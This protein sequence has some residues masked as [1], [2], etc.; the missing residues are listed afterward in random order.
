M[1]DSLPRFKGKDFVS[2]KEC[3]FMFMVAADK[4][5]FLLVY[6][7]ILTLDLVFP[8][9][10]TVVTYHSHFNWKE[11]FKLASC[12]TDKNTF[13]HHEDTGLGVTSF[14][15]SNYTS[16]LLG[17]ESTMNVISL[18]T[19]QQRAISLAFGI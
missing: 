9:V 1:S 12:Q 11:P 18:H 5:I 7:F 10:L 4:G 15:F 14:S 8:K 2:C 13:W 6:F 16:L 17:A 19:G 3:L